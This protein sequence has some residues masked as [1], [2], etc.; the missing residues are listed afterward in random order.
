[1]SET[2]AKKTAIVRNQV[3]VERQVDPVVRGDWS[4]LNNRS[5]RTGSVRRRSSRIRSTGIL[6]KLAVIVLLEA[7]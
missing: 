6:V 2:R 5:Q 1:M 4:C 3:G 7:G